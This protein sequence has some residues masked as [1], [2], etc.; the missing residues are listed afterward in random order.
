M[1]VINSYRF[2]AAY[3]SSYFI[4]KAT[5]TSG[6]TLALTTPPAASYSNPDFTLDW[7]DGTEK[8]IDAAS[9]TYSNTYSISGDYYIIMKG[10]Y[11]ASGA[12]MF[13]SDSKVKFTEIVQWG[14][15]TL[16]SCN[17]YGFNSLTTIPDDN[18]SWTP[19]NVAGIDGNSLFRE[20]PITLVPDVFGNNIFDELDYAFH[21]CTSIVGD[22]PDGLFN[23]CSNLTTLYYAFYNCSGITGGVPSNMLSGCTSLS[24]V[25]RM[26]R[27]CTSLDGT[28]GLGIFDDCPLYNVA[29]C[30]YNCYNLTGSIPAGLFLNQTSLTYVADGGAYNGLFYNCYNLTGSIPS[31]MFSG[32]TAI[33]Y[34]SY[35]NAGG[36]TFKNCSGL[37]GSIPE[38]LLS[39][40]SNIIT[41]EYLFSG[42]YGLT[43]SIPSDIFSNCVAVID[44]GY[45]FKDCYGLD[46]IIPSGLFDNCLAAKNMEFLFQGCYNLTGSIPAG[47]FANCPDIENFYYTFHN[48][49][50]LSG[51]FPVDIFDYSDNIT[52]TFRMFYN[53]YN[54]TG[55]IPSMANNVNLTTVA[56]M[57]LGCT[58]LSGDIPYDMFSGCRS[59][60]YVCATN[61]YTGCFYGCSGL[62]IQFTSSFFSGCTA[63]THVS[64]S[65]YK[66]RAF[67]GV[68]VYGEIPSSLFSDCPNLQYVSYL[69][70]NQIE[71]TSVATDFINETDHPNLVEVRNMLQGCTGVVSEVPDLWNQIFDNL[72]NYS[73]CYTGCISASNY[74]NIPDDWK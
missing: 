72:T 6:D 28:I 48:C 32:C 27:D 73:D 62:S 33:T 34:L 23:G 69:F 24:I 36:G 11:A 49:Y 1:H 44:F 8:Y 67:Y 20:C 12:A 42:C 70:T 30:F 74:D 60:Q 2:S 9:T 54:L 51:E 53:C 35:S 45:I 15:I 10:N 61:A 59:L 19:Y 41:I 5:I 64:Y 47:L 4:L 26:F 40:C 14:T 3:D 55:C 57:Y 43:G 18:I 39:D 29:G 63:L 31:D 22:I 71:I 7:G 46:G 25:G 16:R 21:N 38:G 52:T 66:D 13:D 56:G 68:N 50:G 37:T 17:F 58:G 65:N